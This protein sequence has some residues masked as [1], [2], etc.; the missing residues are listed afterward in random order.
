MK[1]NVD[2]TQD[3][4]F[5]N[6][7]DKLYSLRDILF[8]NFNKF[9]WDF[10]NILNS[11]LNYKQIF[12]TGNKKERK[13]KKMNQNYKNQTECE[14][15]GKDLSKKKWNNYYGLCNRCDKRLYLGEYA[16]KKFLNKPWLKIYVE[17]K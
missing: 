5:R 16:S 11:T 6:T 7:N 17:K 9:P 8:K 1:D 4:D 3:K 10:K 13:N 2:L 14:C 12:F 15:C